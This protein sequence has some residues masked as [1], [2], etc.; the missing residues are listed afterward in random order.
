MHTHFLRWERFP[1]LDSPLIWHGFSLR[2]PLEPE[3]LRAVLTTE[4][5]EKGIPVA[6]WVEAAQPHGNQ[7]A[8]VRSPATR[9]FPG[10]DGLL[11]ALRRVLLAVR[12]A[13]C[14]AVYLLDPVRK[15]IGLLH[16]GRKGTA[17]NIVG[18][19]I[20][21]MKRQWGCRPWDIRLQISPCIRPP[22][23][24]V[25]FAAEIQRQARRAG[26]VHVY[27][28]GRCTA[29]DPERY[30]SYRRD[31]GKTGRMYAFILLR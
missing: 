17:W 19:A 1:E 9:Y 8:V 26:V 5:R 7:V 22:Y 13:D 18:A 16:S 25:D 30:D 31:R 6:A 3:V 24:E 15:V 4:L 27:D 29:A 10:A 21:Q 20:A 2:A 23:Y 12:V 14:A 28:S 11:T